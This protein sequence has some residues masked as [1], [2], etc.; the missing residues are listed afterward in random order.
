MTLSITLP[1]TARNVCDCYAHLFRGT[2]L[3]WS[4]LGYFFA[5]SL[6]GM[7]GLCE[8]A[9]CF[10]FSPS[11]SKLSLAA[12]YFVA[13]PFLRRMRK[14]IFET[15]DTDEKRAKLRLVIDD[16]P[17]KKSGKKI[18]AVGHRV[19]S[20][21]KHYFG[22]QI[23]V[24]AV[25]DT[26]LGTAFPL[27]YEFILP[28]TSP[29][30]IKPHQLALELLERYV[31][32]GHPKMAVVADSGF[33]SILLIEG[34][35]NLGLQFFVEM[36]WNRLLCHCKVARQPRKNQKDYFKG[37]IRRAVK[38][39]IG[40]K[41]R[42]TK[43]V[44]YSHAYISDTKSPVKVACVFNTPYGNSGFGCYLTTD[45][46]ADG[47]TLWFMSRIRWFIE[48]MFRD[49]KQT[50]AFGK[51]P[52]TSKPDADLTVCIPFAL[53]VHLRLSQ[54]VKSDKSESRLETIGTM[55][56]KIRENALNKSLHLLS[57]SQNPI[58]KERVRARRS[59]E[60][61]HKKPVNTVAGAA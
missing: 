39:K 50:F 30:Y 26:E 60:R 44:A 10:V 8:G 14:M 53:L 2:P 41:A 43:Y 17:N 31:A 57:N 25:V 23:L 1:E 45:M 56:E 4:P 49:L 58:V 9:R 6:F 15:Y 21:K 7:E 42:K 55:V 11:V 13:A 16:T 34:C 48:C 35:K 33:D 5:I 51:L 28:K 38:L 47:E 3:K 18:Y 12:Q 40:G 54:V 37:K 20:S 19:E 32:E 52:G 22:Q 36:K 27:D 59:Q 29:S 24:L 46:N 61:I